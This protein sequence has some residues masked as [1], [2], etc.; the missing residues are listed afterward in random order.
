LNPHEERALSFIHEGLE[1]K[2]PSHNYRSTFL[3]TYFPLLQ[4]IIPS[5]PHTYLSYILD[6]ICQPNIHD[7]L[8][9]LSPQILK[10]WR[11]YSRSPFE[12][13]LHIFLHITKLTHF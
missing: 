6:K 7:L 4:N 5:N 12:L 1:D 2:I 10:W 8:L 11:K 9:E 3:S 13:F